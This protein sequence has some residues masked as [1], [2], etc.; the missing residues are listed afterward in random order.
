M[1]PWP[2]PKRNAK[3]SRKPTTSSNITAATARQQQQQQTETATATTKLLVH[4]NAGNSLTWKLLRICC[5]FFC[6]A[7]QRKISKPPF[8]NPISRSLYNIAKLAFALFFFLFSGFL[9]W[10]CMM[11]SSDL[12]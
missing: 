9:N 2:N 4:I 7:C 6:D 8:A 5:V 11:F 3:P 12:F 10:D 1:P